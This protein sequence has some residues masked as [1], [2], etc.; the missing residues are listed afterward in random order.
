MTLSELIAR[1]QGL[2][3]S[4]KDSGDMVVVLQVEPYQY[5][6]LESIAFRLQ[7]NDVILRA[8]LTHLP[9]RTLM[10]GHVDDLLLY[11]RGQGLTDTQWSLLTSKI[12]WAARVG[13]VWL[14]PEV[15]TVDP[16]LTTIQQFIS[17]L[18]KEQSDAE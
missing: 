11:L 15:H 16:V 13:G 8:H 18:V 4:L 7:A 10:S 17:D 6:P 12:G 1:L 3:Q 2:Q 5:V 14:G 9:D